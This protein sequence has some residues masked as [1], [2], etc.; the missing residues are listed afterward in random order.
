[1]KDFR[2]GPGRRQFQPWAL[3]RSSSAARPP[4][5]GRGGFISADPTYL[6]STLGSARLGGLRS[7]G[8][9]LA[10]DLA[11]TQGGV[12]RQAR[13]P[14]SLLISLFALLAIPVL[15]GA[16]IAVDHVEVA[17]LLAAAVVGWAL[18]D[19]MSLASWVVLTLLTS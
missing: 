15:V 16:A 12:T 3:R 2:L 7:A 8:R 5:R 9:P 6:D 10:P 1:M 14:V 19:K 18:Y 4:D 17:L 11:G 13:L